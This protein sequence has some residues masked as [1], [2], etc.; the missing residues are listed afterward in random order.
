[1]IHFSYAPLTNQ[2]NEKFCL[3]D[4]ESHYLV[5]YFYPK[6]NTPGC[7]IQAQK[8]N[9]LLEEFAKLDTVVVG[10]G[11]GDLKSKQ[12]FCQKYD[13]DQIMAIDPDFKLGKMLEVAIQKKMFS[14]V[15][16]TYQRSSFIIDLKTWTILH[17][18]THTSAI[19]DASNNLNFLL[20]IKN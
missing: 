8:Y 3:R 2:A 5:L 7:S 18:D 15:Y 6:D 1:M 12:K 16:W 14:N 13:L 19:K 11:K 10:I 17:Q 20:K 4:L 9:A